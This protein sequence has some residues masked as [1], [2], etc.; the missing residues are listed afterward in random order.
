MKVK[1]Q[2][3]GGYTVRSI[4]RRNEMHNENETQWAQ[5]ACARVAQG[6]WNGM[7]L[8]DREGTSRK[9]NKIYIFF[10]IAKDKEMLRNIGDNIKNKFECKYKIMKW[11]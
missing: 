11:R 2:T 1:M 7:E 9:A 5:F 6:E 3:A 4:R 10:E 8:C